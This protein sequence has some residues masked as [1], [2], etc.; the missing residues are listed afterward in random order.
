M[1]FTSWVR[2]TLVLLLCHAASAA[3]YTVSFAPGNQSVGLGGE[4]TVTVWAED[5]K[6]GGLGSYDLEVFFDASILGFNRVI[7]AAS[8][9]FS[10]G[11]GSADGAGW[12][13]L[14]D[15]SLDDPVSLLMAQADDMPLF[16]LVFDT[17]TAGVGTLQF[18]MVNLSDVYGNVVPVGLGP[19]GAIEVVASSAVPAPGALVLALTGLAALVSRS[20]R[21]SCSKQD[22]SR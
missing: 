18:S 19:A 3:A 1:K 13:F 2:S 4:A 20:R 6:P 5:I 16:Q 7:D 8:L 14:S 21:V 17:L 22:S 15:F 12:V 11:V 9:G 10:M